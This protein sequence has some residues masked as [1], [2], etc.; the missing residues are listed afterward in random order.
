VAKSGHIV[1]GDANKILA[2]GSYRNIVNG[3]NNKIEA[4]NGVKAEG[5]SIISGIDNI[6][7]SRFGSALGEGLLV[8]GHYGPQLA[9]GKYNKLDKFANFVVGGG[10]NNYD[11]KNLFTVKKDGRAVLGAD[12]VEDM[13]AATKRYVDNCET[14]PNLLNDFDLNFYDR[15]D[16]YNWI[17]IGTGT[18]GKGTVSILG[19][20]PVYNYPYYIYTGGSYTVGDFCPDLVIGQYY[21]FTGVS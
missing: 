19:G 15:S 10:S 6:V 7:N 1:G 12:P 18:P 17:R 14:S 20:N 21:V 3:S 16:S 4:G 5:Y 8:A 13:D 2:E 9:I 11:R